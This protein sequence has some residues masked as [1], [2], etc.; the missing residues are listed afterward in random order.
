MSSFPDSYSS[1]GM[2]YMGKL[3][4]FALDPL[5]FLISMLSLGSLIHSHG[6]IYYLH[7]LMIRLFLSLGWASLLSSRFMP[8]CLLSQIQLYVFK[9]LPSN[10]LFLQYLL[11]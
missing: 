6:V 9:T 10:L 3:Q 2:I 8:S 1:S 7:V 4:A 11:L 5:L